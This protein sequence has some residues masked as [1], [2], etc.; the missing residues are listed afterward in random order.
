MKY[1]L[2]FLLLGAFILV[3]QSMTAQ[4]AEDIV[5]ESGE[6]VL[7]TEFID[8]IV[9]KRL[10]TESR[11]L[12][13]DPLREADIPWEKRVWRIIDVRE[14]INR[15]FA[16]PG[17][18]FFEIL[19]DGVRN[20]ELAAFDDDTFQN[21]L[22]P[23][24]VESQMMSSDTT[25]VIDPDTYETTLEV[26]VNSINPEDI[27][28]FRVKEIWY[29]DEES[30][31]MKVRILGIAPIRDVYDEASGEFLYPLPMF[32]VYYPQAREELA[33]H[34]AFN[35]QNDASPM[36]WENLFEIR[37]FSSYIQKVSN[38]SDERLVD[39]YGD[40]GYEMLL[41]SDRIK[42]ELFNFEH[43]LWSY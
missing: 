11:V 15:P 27:K 25:E 23:S 21:L 42:M 43:D 30:A 22:D 37:N 9:K 26:V 35:E 33:K 18:Y 31:A 1:V 39:I 41:E 13:Y 28:R 2:N 17:Q 38:V 16:Y 8:D 24:D 36:T 3:A 6:P 20:G 7:E 10:I 34:R 32:W 12:P 14:K 4:I 19:M 5:T 29:F 40:N